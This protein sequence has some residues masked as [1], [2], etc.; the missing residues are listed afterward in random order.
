MAYT[1]RGT[2][3]TICNCKLLCPCSVDGVPTGEGDQCHGFAVYEVREGNL[4][5]TDLSGVSF[6]LAYFL[7]SN[8]SSGNWKV[9][10]TVDDGASDGQAAAIDRIVSGQEGGPFGEFAP[11]IGEY[12]GMERGSISISDGDA[13]SGTVADIGEFSGDYFKGAD[14]TP[15][16]V[17]NAIFGFAPVYRVG[18]ATSGRFSVFGESYDSSYAEAAE[19][20]YSSEMG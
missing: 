20:E 5:D 4:D 18:K 1:I 6:A 15:T 19:Y 8:A 2:Y 12:V 17:T 14:G 16:T 9:R 13:P 11:L 3:T 10:I 7:P